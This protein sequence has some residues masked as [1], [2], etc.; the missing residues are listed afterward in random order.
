MGV[1][2]YNALIGDACAVE[3]ARC[4]LRR[5]ARGVGGGASGRSG[6]G[7]QGRERRSKVGGREERVGREE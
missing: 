3:T 7:G 1:I 6:G 5:E 4:D 2:T